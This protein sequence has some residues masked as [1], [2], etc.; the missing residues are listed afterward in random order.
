MTIRASL[1][2]LTV[3]GVTIPKDQFDELCKTTSTYYSESAVAFKRLDQMSEGIANLGTLISRSE[4]QQA[5]HSLEI[6]NRVHE[7]CEAS[8]AVVHGSQANL[9]MMR[10]LKRQFARSLETTME[11]ATDIRHI[12]VLLQTLSNKILRNIATNV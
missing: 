5:K 2:K 11:I 9:A 8:Q 10:K 7:L 4:V 6:S 3:R 12:F 1:R